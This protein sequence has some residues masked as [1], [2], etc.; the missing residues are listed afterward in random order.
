VE[1]TVTTKEV[2]VRPTRE[3]DLEGITRLWHPRQRDPNVFRWLLS[4]GGEELRSYVAAAGDQIVGHIGYVMSE[5]SYKGT[6]YKGVFTIEWKVD[7]GFGKQAALALYSKML[8]L[9]DFTF[10]IGGT[11]VVAKIYPHLKF[12]VPLQVTRFLKV[13]R[14]L[15]YFKVLN[16]NLL[17][18]IPKTAFYLRTLLVPKFSSRNGNIELLPFDDNEQPVTDDFTVANEFKK[19]HIQWLM[20][21][22]GMMS[23]LFSIRKKGRAIGTV[24]CYVQNIGGIVTGRI[25][26]ISNLGKDISLWREVVRKIDQFLIERDCCIIT[27]MASYSLFEKA[28]NEN[29][30]LAV[31]KSPFW[32]RD[33]K[34]YFTDAN[35]HLTYM[36]GDMAY[37]EV[38]ISDFVPQKGRVK[39]IV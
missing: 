7:E 8:K 27:T 19:D 14:P 17:K 31:R 23:Y 33:T 4:N 16:S 39:L 1:Q 18:K 15:Q 37:R 11:D 20:N 24:L 38:Y 12:R 35:W 32:L 5:Y 9:G 13:T 30:H 2:V 29:G 10:V 22:P 3:E 28:L 21:A 25:V 34:K 6:S 36:E 26:H